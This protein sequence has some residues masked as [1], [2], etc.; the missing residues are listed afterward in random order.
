[1]TLPTK[2]LDFL[3]DVFSYHA[4]TPEQIPKYEALRAAAKAFAV[5]VL[6][7]APACADRTVAL[8][9]I[10]EAIMVAN[11]AVALEGRV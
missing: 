4:P 7:Y 11:S 3:N 5:E 1:M 10:R 8:R 6:T 2:D 9:K